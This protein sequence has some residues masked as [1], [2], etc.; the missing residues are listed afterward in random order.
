MAVGYPVTKATLDNRAGALVEQLRQIFDG[1][2]SLKAWLDARPDAEL[3][4]DYGYSA[5]DVAVLK[6]AITDLDKLRRIGAGTEVQAAVSDFFF[7]ADRLTG[8]V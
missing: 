8:I 5:E 2:E 1:V 7:W 3:Q 4:A 6:S